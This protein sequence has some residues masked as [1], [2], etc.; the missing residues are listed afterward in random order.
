VLK[1]L[2]RIEA[3]LQSVVYQR[4]VVRVID[5]GP[6]PEDIDSLLMIRTVFV[7]HSET[8]ARRV[9]NDSATSYSPH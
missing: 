7:E 9:T 4:Q 2:E 3:A 5:P 6:L 8:E 1:R